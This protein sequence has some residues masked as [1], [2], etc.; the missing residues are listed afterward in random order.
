MIN[1]RNSHPDGQGRIGAGFAVV[2]RPT[3][4]L[5]VDI[6]R[7]DML[8]RLPDDII[9]S[10]SSRSRRTH[11]FR[12][13]VPIRDEDPRAG[14]NDR[15]LSGGG[16]GSRPR[17]RWRTTFSGYGNPYQLTFGRFE[18]ESLEGNRYRVTA[19]GTGVRIDLERELLRFVEYSRLRGGPP[20]PTSLRP[21]SPTTRKTSGASVPRSSAEPMANIPNDDVRIA[22][23][24]LA[25]S[26]RWWF[27]NS[28]AKA[29]RV[30]VYRR[31][32]RTPPTRSN[33]SGRT[34]STITR[35]ASSGSASTSSP[36]D[37]ATTRSSRGGS[38]DDGRESRRQRSSPSL[39]AGSAVIRITADLDVVSRPVH[40][41]TP[42]FHVRLQPIY[43]P[44]AI[45]AK[46]APESYRSERVERMEMT[47]PR[48]KATP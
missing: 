21:T 44:G 7:R 17:R 12:S 37:E 20:A 29:F 35:R 4:G 8:R 5:S 33:T 41:R 43:R 24:L 47:I 40:H 26:T 19:K 46:K 23:T 16:F 38:S 32:S 3:T 18:V 15:A 31:R 2:R 10:R 1:D 45:T 6:S 13:Q 25:S 34:T 36:W 39:R 48:R 22:E 30:C 42:S 9:V 27:G 11:A 14:R 28:M